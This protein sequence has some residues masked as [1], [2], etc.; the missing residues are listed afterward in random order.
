MDIND[1][2]QYIQTFASIIL[3]IISLLI[4]LKAIYQSIKANLIQQVV[5][6]IVTAEGEALLTGPEKMN[7]VISWMKDIIP[8]LFKV[9]FDEKVLRMIAQ[10]IFSDMKKYANN[11]VENKTGASVDKINKIIIVAQE[12]PELEKKVE[13]IKKTQAE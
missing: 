3:L 8:R 4:G 10:N 13:E 6:F 11:Y 9:V 12:V 2:W 7:L 1:I 5:K